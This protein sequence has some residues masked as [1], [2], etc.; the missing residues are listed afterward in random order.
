MRKA[1]LLGLCALVVS[2]IACSTNSVAMTPVQTHARPFALQS[3]S[4][5][6]LWEFPPTFPQAIT[7]AGPDGH[8]W[9]AGLVNNVSTIFRIDPRT[10]R[11]Q[12]FTAPFGIHTIASGPD[13][14]VWFCLG[15]KIGEVS[16]VGIFTDYVAPNPST[17]CSSITSGP[18]G[19]VWIADSGVN[20]LLRVGTGG[21]FTAFLLPNPGNQIGE[22]TG[23]QND[24]VWFFESNLS[25]S[26]VSYINTSTGNITEIPLNMPG[27]HQFGSL[28]T[29]NDGNAYLLD[30]GRDRIYRVK[31]D[32]EIRGFQ[33]QSAFAEQQLDQLNMRT[34]WLS[35]T[36]NLVGWSIQ[37]HQATNYGSP[38]SPNQVSDPVIGPDGNVWMPGGVY[39]LRSLVVVPSSATIRV[40][41]S[42]S[43]SVT[44]TRC[45]QCTWT[46]KSSNPAIASV[47]TVN[48]GQFTVTGESTGAATITV[49]DRNHN[50][51][52]VAITVQ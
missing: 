36:P 24:L 14:Q 39:I 9:A 16:S 15:A 4:P 25:T 26:F 7:L 5:E 19:N 20:Q 29:G 23:G 33:I 31:P 17:I 21:A 46:A 38:P 34:I 28:D 51:V 10:F 41:G 44:E 42:Q 13:R 40:Q 8:M 3:N 11:V 43:F 47:S 6:L 27:R 49:A 37:N 48:A 18:D 1:L 52:R 12:Q 22:V 45:A 32:G 2:A 35:A 50:E 30:V